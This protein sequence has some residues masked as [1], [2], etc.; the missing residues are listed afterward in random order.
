MKKLE[1]TP[2]NKI[3][4]VGSIVIAVSAIAYLANNK[5]KK[6]AIGGAG[7]G[8]IVAALTFQKFIK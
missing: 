5:S 2:T 7:L 3:I 8:L 4:V 6:I 1:N